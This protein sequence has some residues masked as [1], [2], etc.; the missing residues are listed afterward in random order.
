MIGDDTNKIDTFTMQYYYDRSKDLDI[1]QIQMVSFDTNISNAFSL[2]YRE[3]KSWF[4]VEFVNH[5]QNEDF[6]LHL[7]EP[8]FQEVNLYEE[9]LKGWE[10]HQSGLSTYLQKGEK[11]DI[12]PTFFLKIKPQSSKI[13]YIQLHSKAANFGKFTLYTHQDFLFRDVFDGFALYWFYF[14]TMSI[15][16]FFNLFLFLTIRDRIYIYYMGYVASHTLFV[17]VFS[18][19]HVYAG[20]GGYTHE[21]EISV[22]LY[23]LFLALFS[24][25]FFKLKVYMPM[26]DKFFKL[27]ISAL[28]VLTLLA[29]IDYEVWFERAISF[30]TFFAPLLI[31]TPIYV[32]IK[33]HKEMRYYIIGIALYV[34]SAIMFSL[35]TEGVIENSDFNH[36]FFIFGSYI[37]ILFFS[38]LLANR[39]PKMQQAL[40]AIKE[41]KEQILEQKVKERT[42]KI[43]EINHQ[44]V[45]LAKERELM[46]KEIHHRVKNNFQVIIALLGLKA[47]KEKGEHYKNFLLELKNRV[48]SMSL[49]HNYLLKS[50]AFNKIDTQEY[51]DKIISEIEMTYGSKMIDI[52]TEIDAHILSIEESMAVG[53]IVNE[54]LVNAIKHHPH[55]QKKCIIFISFK[56]IDTTIRLIVEDNGV[57]FEQDNISKDGLGLYLI[58]QF[59]HNLQPNRSKS[60]FSFEHGTR[61]ALEWEYAIISPSKSKEKQ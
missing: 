52:T 13:L 42:H 55:T 7:N 61:Y 2:G 28:G 20:L 41:E 49:I 11:H 18:G 40:L 46:V 8:F 24:G 53:V 34:L 9:T 37:E 38:F 48:K 22:P 35:M 32:W 14:G 43:E 39:F 30:A 33:G 47:S 31:V 26:M 19:L 16:I 36:Y 44:L 60:Y 15:V 4:K 3:G 57:G 50:G 54:L 6:V 58:E 29:L 59:S 17:F 27:F 51:F 45:G 12:H 1:E 10:I 23:I 21:L 56:V 25:Y 5:S